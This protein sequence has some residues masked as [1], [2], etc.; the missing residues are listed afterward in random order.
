MYL[1]LNNVKY[2]ARQSWQFRN[3]NVQVLRKNLLPADRKEFNMDDFELICFQQF[4]MN[5]Y[6]MARQTL[7]KES[8]YTTPEGWTHFRR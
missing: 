1:G 8:P 2:F 7:L 5:T 6:K 3:K 4:F